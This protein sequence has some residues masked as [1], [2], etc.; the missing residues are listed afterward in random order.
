MKTKPKK[1]PQPKGWTAAQK[2]ELKQL[3]IKKRG[4]NKDW[5]KNNLVI[6]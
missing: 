4:L 5:A 3:M 1:K 6:L 2:R